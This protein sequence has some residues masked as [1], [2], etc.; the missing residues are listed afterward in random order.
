MPDETRTFPAG[1][2]VLRMDQPYSRIADT[3]LDYQYWAPDDPQRNPYDD[4]GWTFGELFN[5]KVVRVTDVRVLDATLEPVK[6]DM[7]APGDVTGEGSVFAINQNADPSLATLRYR[8]KD[9]TIDV[10]E[11][12]FEAGGQKFNR[13]SFLVTRRSARRSPES[14]RR[15]RAEGDGA[16]VGAVGEDPPR[17]RGARG[18]DAHVDQHAGRGLV[19]PGARSAVDSVHVHQHAGSHEGRRACD[20]STTSSCFRPSGA[21]RARR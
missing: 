6:G 4:T 18:A 8:F 12:P 9:A 11:E 5:V 13:G 10:A 1:S 7:T 21:P 20:R 19:A 16:R 14:R 17:P 2:Y 15:A 3:L